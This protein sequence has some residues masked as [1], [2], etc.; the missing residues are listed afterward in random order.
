[1]AITLQVPTVGSPVGPGFRL[2][3]TLSGFTF[4]SGDIIFVKIIDHATVTPL[5]V[6]ASVLTGLTFQ[7]HTCGITTA[8]Q[9]PG[10]PEGG[11][12]ETPGA[13]VDIE[14]DWERSNLV[15]VDSQTFTGFTWDPLNMIWVFAIRTLFDISPTGAS[16][17]NVLAAVQ[18][19]YQNTP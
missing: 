2:Q 19:T 16:L 1:M 7:L 12:F 15:T 10:G 11:I 5:L 8:P 6:S 3:F 18:K 9:F 17:A 4:N 13:S 14:L